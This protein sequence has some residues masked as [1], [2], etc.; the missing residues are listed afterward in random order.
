MTRK[1]LTEFLGYTVTI[2]ALVLI[3][4]V[5]RRTDMRGIWHA[6]AGVSLHS[7]ILPLAF[8]AISFVLIAAQEYLAVIYNGSP[9][10]VLRITATSVA[11]VGIGHSIGFA[12][13]SG[14]VIRARMYGR[15]GLDLVAV[16]EI[17]VF[18]GVAL[19]LGFT[20]VAGVL[21]LYKSDAAGEIAHLSPGLMQTAGIAG[22]TLVAMYLLAC[23]VWR[24]TV[25]FRKL[26]FRLP[27]L[28]LA[29]GQ[30]A[31]S[32]ANVM[33]M[34]AVLLFTARHF[35]HLGFSSVLLMRVAADI[36]AAMIHVPG[37]L[38]VQ[39]YIAVKTAGT[40]RILS[41]ML[42]FRGVYYLV[43]LVVGA[44]VFIVDDFQAIVQRLR[45]AAPKTAAIEK[46]E[47]RA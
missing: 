8:T 34:A 23:A 27:S 18:N 29:V 30:I 9:V 45:G 31:V 33:A 22:L 14:G 5:L 24:R 26:R 46:V 28:P 36:A 13:L 6:A 3:C 42:L 38:G 4:M 47:Y 17:I 7:L 2:G 12:F 39:E 16:A 44:A 11:A 20:G 1:R 15:A 37:G 41:G 19:A 32:V 25:T 35:V 10:G 43:P 40:D 21:L